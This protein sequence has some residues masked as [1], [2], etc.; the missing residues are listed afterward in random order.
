MEA[1]WWKRL[2]RGNLGLVLFGGAML[3]KSLIQFSVDEWSCVPSLLFTW[4]QTMVEVMKIT[5]T[6]LKR[7]HAC[8]ATLSVPNPAAGHHWPTP[9]PETLGH[10]QASLG[11]SPVGSL[12]LSSGPWCTRFS[13]SLQESISQSCISSGS[14]I[15]GLMAT[16]S[17]RVYGIS[18]SATPRA[19]VP[20]ADH[21]RPVFPQETLKHSSASVF[22]GFL[23][24]GA[25]KFHLRPLSISGGNGV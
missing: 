2:L 22:L 8:S 17:K 9:P 20:A 6:S 5:V 1:S 12:L 13:C 11:Q 7:S 23:G 14:T 4:G 18:K 19:S 21:R 16:S 3:S 24:P 25:H 10:T 15:V